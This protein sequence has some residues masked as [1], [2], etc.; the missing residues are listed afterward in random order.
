LKVG[1]EGVYL[2]GAPGA[3]LGIAVKIEDGAQRAAEPAL[4]SVLR[5]LNLLTD[6]E[7]SGL[8]RFVEPIL[9]NTR[10]EEVGVIRA[11]LRLEPGDG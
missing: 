4:I 10:N 7:V 8:A 11:A 2:A 9:R 5:S 6:D 1:A 3:E